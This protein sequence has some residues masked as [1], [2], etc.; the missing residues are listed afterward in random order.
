MIP[1]RQNIYSMAGYVPGYQP[2]DIASWI[3]LNTNENPYPPSPKVREAILAELGADAAN[4]RTYPSASSQELREIAGALYGFD[5]SWVIMANGSDELLNNLI[6]AFAAEGEE[7][8][9]IH[10]SY[11]YYATLAEIQGA[12]VRTFELTDDLWIAGFPEIYDGKLFFLTTPNSPLG[13]AFSPAY[14]EKLAL[15]CRGMLVIDEAYADFAGWNALELVKKYDNVVVTR[16]LSKSYSLAGM[17]LGLAIAR[18]EVIR[19]LDKIRDHYNL[20][21]LAQAACGAALQ[22]QEYFSEACRKVVETR[23]WFTAELGKAGYTVIPSS[24]NFVFASPPDR[25][26]KRVYDGLYARK[27]LVRHFSD[28]LLSHGLRISIGTREEMETTLKALNEIG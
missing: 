24:G 1:L 20:D 11:S 14:I 25:D 22:D 5:P 4:L 17:R 27:I 21:R 15:R 7:I 19:A 6:R 12:K 8:A 28:P 18:P 13:F 16:T 26:G 10:P 3:K 2:P 23:E 9:Y